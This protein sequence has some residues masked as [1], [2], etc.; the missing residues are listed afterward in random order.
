[1]LAEEYDDYNYEVH[2]DERDELS[3]QI[4]QSIP[5]LGCL[6][7]DDRFLLETQYLHPLLNNFEPSED[8]IQ[9]LVNKK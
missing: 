4:M 3:S 7:S 6:D 1:L 5:A 9:E 8:L 2:V